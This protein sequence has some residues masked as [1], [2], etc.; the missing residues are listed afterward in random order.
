MRSILVTSIVG[1]FEVSILVSEV[2]KIYGFDGRDIDEPDDP[3]AASSGP[4]EVNDT[5]VM[6][7]APPRAV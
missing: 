2:V 7:F 6:E 4:L 1:R 3:S 5:V